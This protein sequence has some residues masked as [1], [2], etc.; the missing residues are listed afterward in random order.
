VLLGSELQAKDLLP[1]CSRAEEARGLG[2]L[3]PISA[4]SASPVKDSIHSNANYYLIGAGQIG[5]IG[6]RPSPAEVESMHVAL[7]LHS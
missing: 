1:G 6:Q 4:Q 7:L 5:T 2:A 3:F